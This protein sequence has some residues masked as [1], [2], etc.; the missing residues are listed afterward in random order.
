MEH[1]PVM[2]GPF[3]A[4]KPGRLPSIGLR[5]GRLPPRGSGPGLDFNSVLDSFISSIGSVFP[6]V[7]AAVLRTGAMEE[8]RAFKLA[9]TRITIF[10]EE[11]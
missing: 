6:T 1:L 5:S 8:K 3:W 2:S 10:R 7:P 11:W 4:L 9:L